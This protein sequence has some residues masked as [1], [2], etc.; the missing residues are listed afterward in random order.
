LAI[1]TQKIE[2][3]TLVTRNEAFNIYLSDTARV[4]IIYG[5]RDLALGSLG[6]LIL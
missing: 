4:R 6:E 1:S 5:M 3:K 2:L